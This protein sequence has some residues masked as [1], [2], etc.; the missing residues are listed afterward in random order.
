MAAAPIQIE[1]RARCLVHYYQYQI[2]VQYSSNTK[3]Y[4]ITIPNTRMQVGEDAHALVHEGLP[5]AEVEEVAPRVALEHGPRHVRAAAAGRH[6]HAAA[7]SARAAAA[8]P[9]ASGD[10]EKHEDAQRG[11]ERHGDGDVQ[12]LPECVGAGLRRKELVDLNFLASA[13]KRAAR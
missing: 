12:P 7:A 4:D 3:D 11:R 5:G 6:H 1:H 2:R 9:A 8:A 10:V 13:E